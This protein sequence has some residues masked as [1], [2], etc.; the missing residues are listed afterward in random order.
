MLFMS[1]VG[2]R[3]TAHNAAGVESHTVLS[4]LKERLVDSLIE[5]FEELAI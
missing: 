3:L 1:T 5:H 2:I 4:W